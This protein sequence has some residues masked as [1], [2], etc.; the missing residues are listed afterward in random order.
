MSN[1][2]AKISLHV[3]PGAARNELAGIK[4]G[5]LQIRVAAPPVKGK[6]NQELLNFIS[7]ILGVNKTSLSIIKGQTNRNKVIAIAGLSQEDAIK[8]LNLELSSSGGDTTR[9]SH[10]Q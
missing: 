1:I 10:R 6:A 5:V 7:R 3:S 8:R 4:D 9:K 2:Q